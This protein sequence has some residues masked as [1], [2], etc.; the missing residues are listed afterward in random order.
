[1]SKVIL[2]T[3]KLLNEATAE[4]KILFDVSEDEIVKQLNGMTCK[5]INFDPTNMPDTVEVCV[6]GVRV[7][8]IPLVNLRKK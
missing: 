2:G 3:E 1:M 6:D 7:S 5:V 8:L 4:D